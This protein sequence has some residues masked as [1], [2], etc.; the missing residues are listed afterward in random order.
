MRSIGFRPWWRGWSIARAG[1]Y[2]AWRF[3]GVLGSPSC[4]EVGLAEGEETEE[5]EKGDLAV[6]EGDV[7]NGFHGDPFS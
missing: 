7:E 6:D 1:R 2:D 5:T 4:F 3:S